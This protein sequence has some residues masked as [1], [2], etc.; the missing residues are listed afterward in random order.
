MIPQ[1]EYAVKFL[2]LLTVLVT[3]Q[4]VADTTHWEFSENSNGNEI[5]W[6][7]PTSVDANADQYEYQYEIT[8]V[9]VD[10]IFLGTVIGPNDVTD[11]IDPALRFGTG[12]EPG[13]TP[14]VFI[15]EPLAADADTDGDIDVAADFFMQLASDGHGHFDVTNVF[16]GDVYVDTGWPFGWQY[17][18]IDR[19]YMDGYIDITPIFNPCPADINDDGMVNVTD[20]LIV[21]ENWGGSGRGDINGDDIVNVTDLLEVVR[22]WGYCTS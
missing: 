18:E 2:S 11:Q 16:L 22:A 9:A 5:H 12:I 3:L 20:I 14:I 17:V 15:D 6:V 21:I 7:S 1:K 10:V 19:I 4:A 13:P 8:Y